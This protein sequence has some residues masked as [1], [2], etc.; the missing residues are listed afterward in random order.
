MSLFLAIKGRINFAQSARYSQHYGE[1]AM[2]DQFSHYLDF[3]SLNR[4]LIHT[5]IISLLRQDA[6]CPTAVF[7]SGA[8]QRIYSAVLYCPF[9]KQNWI[10]I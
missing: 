10:I 2:R 7:A 5:P 9:L 1:H 8:D 6:R 4:S 3:A